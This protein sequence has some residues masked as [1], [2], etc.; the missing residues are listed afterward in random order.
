MIYH[1]KSGLSKAKIFL[2]LNNN[3]GSWTLLNR[4]EQ[5]HMRVSLT[6]IRLRALH[7]G[8]VRGVILSTSSSEITSVVSAASFNVLGTISDNSAFLLEQDLKF[9]SCKW[10]KAKR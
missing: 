6:R 10:G 8:V 4:D 5:S 7:V 2:F 3:V 9:K 1:I